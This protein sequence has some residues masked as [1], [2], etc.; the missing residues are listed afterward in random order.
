MTSRSRC[1]VVYGNHAD[2]ISSAAEVDT[3]RKYRIREVRMNSCASAAA[4]S[5][6]R[7]AAGSFPA[8][9][10]VMHTCPGVFENDGEEILVDIVSLSKNSSLQWTAVPC[11]LTLGICPYFQRDEIRLTADVSLVSDSS[12]KARFSCCIVDE[13]KIS[14]LSQLGSIPYSD[15]VLETSRIGKRG[16]GD[17]SADVWRSGIAVGVAKALREIEKRR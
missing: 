9:E 16:H 1:E 15:G 13:W 17:V 3:V 2:V 7:E 14:F 11:L 8:V 12:R 5:A 4:N 6:M 10:R